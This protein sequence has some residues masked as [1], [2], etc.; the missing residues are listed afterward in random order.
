MNHQQNDL[1]S[2]LHQPIELTA[3]ADVHRA[4][5]SAFSLMGYALRKVFRHSLGL[6]PNFSRNCSLKLVLTEIPF[7][8]LP[9]L[10]EYPCFPVIP[11]FGEALQP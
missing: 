4:G 8:Q 3:K 7:V 10:K 9:V 5:S 2:V 6:T 11:D 1:T